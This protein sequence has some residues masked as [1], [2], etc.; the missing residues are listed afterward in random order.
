[1]SNGNKAIG[2]NGQLYGRSP[3][4]ASKLLD[5]GVVLESNKWVADGDNYKYVV[6][7]RGMPATTTP[8]PVLIPSGEDITDDEINA[9]AC[10]IIYNISDIITE[11]NQIVFK[12][13]S[14]PEVNLSL[15]L[16]GVIAS[17]YN[18]LEDLDEII[19]ST[20]RAVYYDDEGILTE[21]EPRDADTLG[22]RFN[23]DD[24]ADISSKLN[25]LQSKIK[26]VT[27]ELTTDAN[28]NA[29][30]WAQGST[31]ILA[32]FGENYACIP[33]SSYNYWWAKVRGV[34]GIFASVNNTT[35][36]ATIVYI[37]V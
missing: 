11:D 9:Y 19:E 34:D 20:D 5:L 7:V 31:Y 35:F 3:S 1:M 32:V 28:G 24:I 8:V 21:A 25:G 6:P 36:N 10:L 15:M 37:E 12:A 17:R 14:L 4:I 26:I 18:A 23:A 16:K 30:I 29:R 13:D 27:R 22:G 2:F 33:T